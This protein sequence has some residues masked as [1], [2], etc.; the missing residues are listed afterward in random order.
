MKPNYDNDNGTIYEIT[1]F[2]ESFPPERFSRIGDIFEVVAMEDGIDPYRGR[3]MQV[4]LYPVSKAERDSG[5]E[6]DYSSSSELDEL[7]FEHG[8][9]FGTFAKYVKGKIDENT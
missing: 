7:D 4:K 8:F 1:E 9:P 2:F 3:Y 6:K 5:K